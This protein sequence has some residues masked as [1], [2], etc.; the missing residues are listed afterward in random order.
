MYFAKTSLVAYGK[1]LNPWMLIPVNLSELLL[2]LSLGGTCDLRFCPMNG[3]V[4]DKDRDNRN[5][6]RNHLPA[7]K[8]LSDCMS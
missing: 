6:S 1:K 5:K 7:A 2:S 3:E 4:N 8:S